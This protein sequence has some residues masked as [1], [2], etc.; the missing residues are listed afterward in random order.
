MPKGPQ[1]PRH[2][3]APYSVAWTTGAVLVLRRRDGR[4]SHQVQW[5]WS[6]IR[7]G[8][9]KGG[10]GQA[11]RVG[12]A[13]RH[14]AHREITGAS[15]GRGWHSHGLG[16]IHSVNVI[17]PKIAFAQYFVCWLSHKFKIW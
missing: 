11:R 10:P 13:F 17:R 6:W 16:V 3:R 5:A 4:C 12:G 8:H 1:P 15:G 14:A 2:S 9:P 7:I